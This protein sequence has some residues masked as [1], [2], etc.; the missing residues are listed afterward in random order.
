MTTQ[1]HAVA[2]ITGAGSGIGRALTLLLAER[3]VTVVASDRD[4]RRAEETRQLAEGV[5]GDVECEE[6]DVTNATAVAT[7]VQAAQTRH[8]RIDYLFNN[9]GIAVAGEVQNVSLEDWNAVLDVNLH[10]VVHG[11]VAAYG[12][13]AEQ[14]FGHIVNTASIEGLAPFPGTV[15]YVASKHAVVGLSTA[16]RAEGADLGVRVSA[17]CPG[18][19]LTR[20]FK[21]T[22]YVGLERDEVL[23][24]IPEWMGVDPDEC[25]KRIMR[26]VD[27]NRSIIPITGFA[28]VL[29]ILMRLSPNLVL[30]MMQRNL[31]R[32]RAQDRARKTNEGLPS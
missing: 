16:L 12:I 5:K 20:I 28:W 19:I 11:V 23:E 3:G 6:L 32:G 24:A 27:R 8:G 31:R 26:G 9:A 29:W 13:M 4:L 18:L 21:D 10:G 22:K 30:G 1:A 17:V 2:L 15:S 7:M 25:A 14:G